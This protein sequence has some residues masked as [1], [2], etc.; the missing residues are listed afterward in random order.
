MYIESMKKYGNTTGIMVSLMVLVFW[1]VI[2]FLDGALSSQKTVAVETSIIEET[3]SSSLLE[4]PQAS[5]EEEGVIVHAI[6]PDQEVSE[7]VTETVHQQL[8]NSEVFKDLNVLEYLY[9]KNKNT[10]L[11]QPMIEKFLQHYQFDKANYYLDLLVK[12]EGDY[13]KVGLDP[14]QV[15]YAR[16]HDFS[17]GLDSNNSLDI[18]FDLVDA[19]RS[20]DLISADD[21]YFYKWLQA[22]RVYNYDLASQAFA[23]ITDARYKDFKL[24]YEAALANYLKIKNP[25]A[26][27]RDGLV[28]LTLLKN[29]Y[30][31]FAK[32]LA[33]RALSSHEEYILSYQVLAYTNFLTHN[34]EAAK[35]YFLKLTTIDTK[36]TFLYKFLIGISYYRHG[37]YEQS[38]LYLNQVTDPGLTIDV[39]RYMLLSYIQGGDSDNILRMFQNLLGE[40]WLQASDF[41]LFFDQMFYTPFRAGQ[42]FDLYTDSPQLVDLYLGK[43]TTV[44]DD[45]QADVC[46]YGEV[47]LQLAKQNLSWIGENI[48]TLTQKYKQSH[49]YHILGDYYSQQKQY[50]VAKETYVQALSICEQLSEQTILK[51]K[52][53]LLEDKK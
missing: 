42:A 15:L 52:I 22:L 4:E 26:Y 30:F 16:F 19:Y 31:S 2:L 53:N 47:W 3:G 6:A 48:L 40:S 45:S 9:G 46:L 28:A 23:K 20:R 14:H 24:S 18:V 13:F 51:N 50:T 39:Y 1:L 44:L 17:L 8:G 37:D 29:W 21:A 11:L 7:M 33:L 34:W 5:Q 43:C 41:A 32:R 25:P 36:N 35:D 10:E 27:Y 49:L 38:I 12:E